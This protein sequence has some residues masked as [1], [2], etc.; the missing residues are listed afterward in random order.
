ML[1]EVGDVI[2]IFATP[3]ETAAIEELILNGS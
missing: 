1:I 3:E 2:V